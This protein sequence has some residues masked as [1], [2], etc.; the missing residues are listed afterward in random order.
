MP[1]VSDDQIEQRIQEN[2]LTAPRVTPD[3]LDS[4]ITT[5]HYWQVPGTTVTVCVLELKNGFSVV[6]HSACISPEN[7]DLVLGQDIAYTMARSRIWEL[8]AYRKQ[9]ELYQVEQQP[10]TVDHKDQH[11]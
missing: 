2:G 7:F 3:E 1:E 5:A 10:C 11:L 4:L 9:Q 8:E 6:G